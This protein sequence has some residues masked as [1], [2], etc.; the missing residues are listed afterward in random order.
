MAAVGMAENFG[1]GEGGVLL[2]SFSC[3][4]SFSTGI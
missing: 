1:D 2:F 3:S 4:Y